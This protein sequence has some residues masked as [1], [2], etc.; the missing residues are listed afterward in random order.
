MVML[1]IVL[2]LAVQ[3]ATAPIASHKLAFAQQLLTAAAVLKPTPKAEFATKLQAKEMAGAWYEYDGGDDDVGDETTV[4]FG[5]TVVIEGLSDD[6]EEVLLHEGFMDVDF[7]SHE[8]DGNEGTSDGIARIFEN[9]EADI[10]DTPDGIEGT[11][12]NDEADIEGT[13]DGI[14]GNIEN[15]EADIEGTTDGAESTIENDQAD[16]EM[17]QTPLWDAM[18]HT[19]PKAKTKAKKNQG[20]RPSKSQQSRQKKKPRSKPKQDPTAEQALSV[21]KPKAQPGSSVA[22]GVVR[23]ATSSADGGECYDTDGAEDDGIEVAFDEAD[24]LAAD[25]TEVAADEAD[26]E[27]HDGMEVAADEADI[28]AADGME[29]ATDE[30]DTENDDGIAAAADEADIENEDGIAATSDADDIE[31]GHT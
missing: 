15:E 29:V 24:M 17:S 6:E 9:D 23:E 13:P 16:I 3:A 31:T 27:A 8:N 7:E 25:G 30:A 21:S 19:P 2:A 20:H 22:A 14:E 26:I 12:E 28:E 11:N 4:G 10:A 1:A 5:T 18:P